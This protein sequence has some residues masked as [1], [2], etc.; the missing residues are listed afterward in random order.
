ML[1]VA[2]SSTNLQEEKD[3]KDE[4]KDEKKDGDKPKDV[5]KVQAQSWQRWNA[6]QKLP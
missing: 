5:K 6:E 2:P 1:S 3:D 4:K